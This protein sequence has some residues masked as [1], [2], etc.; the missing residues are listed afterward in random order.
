MIN[1]NKATFVVASVASA[2]EFSVQDGTNGYMFNV[3]G[4]N[5][6]TIDNG[7]TMPGNLP[8]NKL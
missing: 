2:A 3:D 4:A 5:M 8:E 1:L 7:I 6:Y